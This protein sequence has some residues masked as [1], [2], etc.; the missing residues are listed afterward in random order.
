MCVNLFVWLVGAC[1]CMRALIPTSSLVRFR[2][3]DDVCVRK[4]LVAECVSLCKGACIMCVCGGLRCGCLFVCACVCQLAVCLQ[5][6]YDN[7][8]LSKYVCLSKHTYF[9]LSDDLNDLNLC[10]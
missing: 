8:C 10:L 1:A 3:R 7:L 4:S 9:D 6:T 5:S 2:V